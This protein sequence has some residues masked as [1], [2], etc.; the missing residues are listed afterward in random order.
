MHKLHIA[1]GCF[2]HAA[3]PMGESPGWSWWPDASMGPSPGQLDGEFGDEPKEAA[4]LTVL[5]CDSRGAWGLSPPS[6]Q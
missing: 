3:F 5:S 1:A 2:S 4:E 6:F